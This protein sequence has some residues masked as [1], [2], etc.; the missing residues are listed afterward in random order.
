MRALARGSAT[1]SILRS[2]KELTASLAD[3]A[4]AFPDE[5]VLPLR[6][7]AGKPAMPS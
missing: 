3:P 4:H 7:H 5:I 6:Q 2:S 1:A